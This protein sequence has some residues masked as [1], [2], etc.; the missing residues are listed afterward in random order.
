MMEQHNKTIFKLSFL[1]TYTH[2]N[3]AQTE[4]ILKYG[5]AGSIQRDK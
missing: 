2:W 5:S 3:T 4:I 1:E